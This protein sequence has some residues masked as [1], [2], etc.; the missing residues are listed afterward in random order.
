MGVNIGTLATQAAEHYPE[1]TAFLWGNE[2]IEYG[3]FGERVAALAAAFRSTGIRK[4]DRIALYTDNCP[5]LLECYFAAWQ[6]GACV[7]P[8]NARFVPDEVVYHV[9]NPRARALVF[10]E[11]FKDTV[12]GMSERLLS[13]EHYVCFGDPARGQLAYEE[14][15]AQNLSAPSKP[16]KVTDGDPAWLFY[17]S[18]TTGRPKGA[19]ITHGNL[20][21]V[22]VNWCADLMCIEPEDVGL[23]AAPLSH[24]A[25]FHALALTAKGAAQV[26]AESPRFDPQ[27]FCALVERHRVTNSALVPTQVKR[28]ISF[29]GLDEYDLSTLRYLAY[30][31]SPMYVEDLKDALDKMGRIFVQLYGQGETPMTATYLRREEHVAEGPKELTE[32]LASCGCARTGVEI[33]ILDEEDREVPRGQM[34]EICVRGP[35]VF[36]GYWEKP[37]ETAQTLRN[38][39]LHTGDLGRM[40]ERGYVYVMDRTKD[41]IISGGSNVYP[42]EVEE[43]LLEHPAV[44]EAAVIGVP[45]PEWGES[46]KAVLVLAPDSEVTGEEIIAYCRERMAPYKRPKSVS[47]V[48]ELPKSSID[49]VL[50]RALR[51]KFVEQS[52]ADANA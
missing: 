41:M 37:E 50:K 48:E 38:D 47:F 16:V 43:V 28:L 24:G 4:G 36:A 51:E 27:A 26:I 52:R 32:T 29:E 7:V 19:I 2:V 3:E 12:K 14:L 11:A 40:D 13:V 42:R 22:T 23:H 46:V 44:S 21:F 34:G 30:Y 45:D 33:A 15:V 17:T 1:R 35:S 49:K 39:W 5:Q 9:E 25:G 10:A 6:A 31:G 20:S 18:G 8:L